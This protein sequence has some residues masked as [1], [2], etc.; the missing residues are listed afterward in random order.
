MDKNP[1]LA[2]HETFI[3]LLAG[4]TAGT[5]GA[6]ATCP[7]EVVKTRLQSSA[8]ET[9]NVNNSSMTK[10]FKSIVRNE[11]WRALFKG[12]GPNLIGIAPSRAI[13]FSTYSSVK[14]LLN[15]SFIETPEHP[16]I[17]MTSAASA[18][19]VSCTATNP[20]WLI[21]TRLQLSKETI[22]VRQCV[23]NIWVTSGITGF[24]K[25]ITASYVGI[26]ET[27][28]HF[29]IYEFFKAQIKQKRL[30]N[31]QSDDNFDKYIFFQL[32][33]ASA[34]SK[35]CAC[36]IAYPHEVARTRLRE[37]GA[38]YKTFMQT[39]YLVWREEGPIGLYRG[40]S[41]QLIRAIPFTAITM[42]TY[43]LVVSLLSHGKIY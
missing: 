31:P 6:L 40:L 1:T 43:E 34:A 37:E 24:Y 17:H 18:G 29:V 32:L 33:F 26:S 14:S 13:Y 20:I 38:I 27:I 22:T 30:A 16:L 11:G 7:L 35:S 4:G 9:L 12:I 41:I 28:V 8:K 21:K 23:R 36:A 5:I 39:L 42:S 3:H 10:C 15:E 2:T 25:G 19:F